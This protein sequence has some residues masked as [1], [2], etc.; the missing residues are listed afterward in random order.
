[1]RNSLARKP[2]NVL[3]DMPSR[4]LKIFLAC[5][6]RLAKRDIERSGLRI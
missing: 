3:V 1:M 6:L 5:F 4:M 2:A